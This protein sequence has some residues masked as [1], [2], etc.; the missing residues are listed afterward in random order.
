[1][2]K[3]KAK[4]A[5][6]PKSQQKD[7]T[8]ATIDHDD[9]S[10]IRDDIEQV[11]EGVVQKNKKGQ[12]VEGIL[13]VVSQEIFSGPLPHPRH[14]AAYEEVCPGM[15]DRI[16]TMAE[17]SQ[18]AQLEIPKI[19]IEAESGYRVLGLKLGFA[20][21]LVLALGSIVCAYTGHPKLAAGFITVGALGTV[22][23][24]IDGR[25]DRSNSDTDT[26]NTK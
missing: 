9:L 20:T 1:M 11:L 10:D 14:I 15:A 26:E 16:M 6:T 5:P 12:V 7:N 8:P 23:R 17:K 2:K 21:L 19:M 18:A 24:F 13:Q 4:K 22:G 3:P 25:K